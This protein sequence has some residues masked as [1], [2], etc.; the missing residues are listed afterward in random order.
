MEYLFIFIV[1]LLIYVE[2]KLY[3][4]FLNPFIIIAITY[5]FL[6]LINNIIATKMGFYAVSGNSIL[7]LLYFLILIF[8][9][10]VI[11][12]ILTKNKTSEVKDKS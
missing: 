1:G 12:Y 8:I 9:I 10:S 3:K 4:T 5:T 11:F 7:Y 6:I 2:Y